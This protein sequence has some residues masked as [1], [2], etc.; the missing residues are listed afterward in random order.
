MIRK[1]VLLYAALALAVPLPAL[2]IGSGTDGGSLDVQASLGGC[3][4]GG[5]AIVCR[6]DASFTPIDDAEYYIASV[7]AADGSVTDLGRV[8]AGGTSVP[9]PYAGNGTY[10]VTIT[11]WGYDED[12]KSHVVE[13]DESGAGDAAK[14]AQKGELKAVPAPEP[15]TEDE[16]PPPADPPPP[17]A[18]PPPECPETGVAPAPEPEPEP[19]ATT[20]TTT[21][22]GTTTE[23]PPPPPSP[24]PATDP[25]APEAP[26][27][28]PAPVP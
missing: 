15:G 18:E 20:T 28:A 22:E 1:R 2:A 19:E 25:C 4:V 12:G 6:I 8:E 14:R 3:G 24:A 27:P 9:V 13:E 5:G 26:S 23:P 11:A 16:R 7:T 10:T 21:P 17:A